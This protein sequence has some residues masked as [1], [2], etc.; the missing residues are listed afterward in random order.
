MEDLETS[1]RTNIEYSLPPLSLDWWVKTYATHRKVT[2]S[3]L[4][5]AT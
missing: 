2:V 4:I 1:G 5:L 3:L